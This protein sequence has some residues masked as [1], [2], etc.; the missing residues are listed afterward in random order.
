MLSFALGSVE[1]HSPRYEEELGDIAGTGG[2]EGARSDRE[3][4]SRVEANTGLDILGVFQPVR[5]CRGR[6]SDSE[7]DRVRDV[8]IVTVALLH[9]SSVSSREIH[10]S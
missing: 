4:W 8:A 2:E 6:V 5:R 10:R 7:D 3:L 1:Q 9:V